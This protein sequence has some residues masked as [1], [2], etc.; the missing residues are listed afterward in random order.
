MKEK[1]CSIYIFYREV[2]FLLKY[3]NYTTKIFRLFS[4]I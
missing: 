2:I 3:E 4:V 1:Y